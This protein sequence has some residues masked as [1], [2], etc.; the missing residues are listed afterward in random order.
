M[1][2]EELAQALAEAQERQ[3]ELAAALAEKEAGFAKTQKELEEKLAAAENRN[4]SLKTKAELFDKYIDDIT[5]PVSAT[6]TQTAAASTPIVKT[7]D[8]LDLV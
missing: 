2:E 5:K 4:D 8:T 7:F 3:G 1:T 6:N